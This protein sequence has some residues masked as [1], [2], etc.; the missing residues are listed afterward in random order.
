M[1]PQNIEK[2]MEIEKENELEK[3][4]SGFNMKGS[5]YR[6]LLKHDTRYDP[7]REMHEFCTGNHGRY[8]TPPGV[9]M[10]TKGGTQ[11]G[12]SILGS[13]NPRPYG[14]RSVGPHSKNQSE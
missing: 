10:R 4:M 9:T 2:A 3:V 8:V 5:R 12:G 14:F 6:D 13:K 7:T 11:S 1:T